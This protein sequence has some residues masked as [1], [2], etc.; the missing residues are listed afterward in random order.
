MFLLCTDT[1]YVVSYTG[2]SG[3]VTAHLG[4]RL[5]VNPRGATSTR[6][7]SSLSQTHTIRV[8]EE[9]VECEWEEVWVRVGVMALRVE[10]AKRGT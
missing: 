10:Y 6:D 2:G 9:M 8:Y 7:L 1:L 4:L 5:R 3:G